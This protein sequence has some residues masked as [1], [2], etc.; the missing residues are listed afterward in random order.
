MIR[1]SG[2]RYGKQNKYNNVRTRIDGINFASKAEARRY[3]SLKIM[4][5]AGAIR[6]FLM[7]VP[8]HIPGEPKAVRYVL[9]F[10]ICY[11]DGSIRFEDVKGKTTRLFLTKQAIVQAQYGVKIEIVK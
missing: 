11:A 9:D 2:T 3:E 4:K 7:Q 10:M 1:L 5:Q 8:F 6:W